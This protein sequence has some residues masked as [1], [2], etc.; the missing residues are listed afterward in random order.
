M[1]FS[2]CLW[3]GLVEAKATIPFGANQVGLSDFQGQAPQASSSD[4]GA[5]IGGNILNKV[6]NIAKVVVASIAVVYLIWSAL[7]LVIFGSNEEEV[8]SA[9]RGVIWSSLAL[10]MMLLLNTFIFDIFFN[11]DTGG[12]LKNESTISTSVKSTVDVVIA[13]LDWF[14][15][16]LVI[17]AIGFLMM[18]GFK[19]IAALGDQEQITGQ[20]K[21]FLW[22]GVGIVVMLLNKVIVQEVVYKFVFS[23]Y[24]VNYSP[25]AN[26]GVSQ[27]MGVIKYFLIALGVAA[28]VAFIYGGSLMITAFGNDERVEEG[29]KIL[30]SAVA[31]ILIILISYAM[32]ATLIQGGFG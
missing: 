6:A 10:I 7:Q 2:C 31:G 15:A 25:D 32:V 19:M 17:I 12:F 27:I 1:I 21:V 30:Y 9:K 23:N 8:S 18:S 5:R 16:I 24:E 13:G 20:K 14:Q 26:A 29:K 28:L 11:P 3:S 22:I 4:A